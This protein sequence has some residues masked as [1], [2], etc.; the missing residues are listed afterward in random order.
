MVKIQSS[1]SVV[2]LA[3]LINWISNAQNL[4][5]TVLLNGPQGIGKSTGVR[6]ATEQLGGTFLLIDGSQLGDGELTG[7]PVPFEKNG[8]TEL[9][10]I[11]HPAIKA[12]SRRQKEYYEKA[13]H[14][15]FLDGRVYLEITENGDKYLHDF[16]TTTKV[17]DKSDEIFKGEDNQYQFGETLSG[18]TKLKLLEAGEIRPV[19]LFIDELNRAEST[20]M[21]QLMNFILNRNVNGYDLP[22]WVD[23][24]SAINPSS[25]NSTYNTNSFDDAQISRFINVPVDAN[26]NDWIDYML[27]KRVDSAALNAIASNSGIFTERNSSQEDTTRVTPDPRAWEMVFNIM[28]FYKQAMNSKYF[29]PEEKK[30]SEK[31]LRI[32]IAGKVGDTAASSFKVAYDNSENNIK[33]SD[34]LNGNNSKIDDAV[35]NKFKNR[36]ALAKKIISDNVYH[37]IA[38][39]FDTIMGWQ[40]SKNAA[41]KTRFK[42]YRSQLSEFVTKLLTNDLQMLFV[43]H[44]VNDTKGRQIF[45]VFSADWGAD[46]LQA[47]KKSKADIESLNDSDNE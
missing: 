31:Y 19:V 3:A 20:T 1:I 17:S 43:R 44:M 11:K 28:R 22:W 26:I 23:I 29:S 13:T 27:T 35:V 46:V 16:D 39:N 34:I 7:W 9:R 25:A 5:L 4:S 41:D 42:N 38:D 10:Y 15:G 40:K 24:V 12:I 30:D 47:I 6:E 14:G 37:E 2:K 21:K 18:E 36:T 32:L 45:G 33:P 8:E